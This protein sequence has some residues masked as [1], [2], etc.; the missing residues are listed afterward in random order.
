MRR[1]GPRRRSSKFLSKRSAWGTFLG[2]FCYK[3]HLVFPHHLAPFVSGKRAPLHK[4]DDGHV[5][6]PAL[7]G[8]AIFLAHRGHIIG[9]LHPP[10]SLT[11]PSAERLPCYWIIDG[12]PGSARQSYP[13]SKDIHGYL[14]P[15]VPQHGPRFVQHMG[16]DSATF[17]PGGG[18]E[19]DWLTKLVSATLA[20][21]VAPWLTGWTVH[22]TGSF[23]YAFLVGCGDCHFGGDGVSVDCRRCRRDP[24]VESGPRLQSRFCRD[25]ETFLYGNR[26]YG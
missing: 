15:R 2:L 4:R 8:V 12:N 13:G 25:F 23:F 7:L 22:Q 21:I 20:G 14:N 19:V 18:R 24:L 5:W 1:Q 16:S 17:R 6:L 26:S 9:L 3:L 10:G 11:H